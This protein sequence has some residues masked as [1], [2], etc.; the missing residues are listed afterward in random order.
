MLFVLMKE[1]TRSLG[2]LLAEI[3]Q[4]E[5]QK[6]KIFPLRTIFH[7]HKRRLQVFGLRAPALGDVL[8]GSGTS[9]GLVYIVIGPQMDLHI[10]S[11]GACMGS[12]GMCG[13]Y[14]LRCL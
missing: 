13:I 7:G 10:H 8:R 1:D 9:C 12:L 2:W 3:K 5:K 6:N 11:E 4:K 14:P